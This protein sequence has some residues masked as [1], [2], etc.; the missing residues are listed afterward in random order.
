MNG[1]KRRSEVNFRNEGF[2]VEK[3]CRYMGIILNSTFY[4]SSE[5]TVCGYL[6]KI[7]ISKGLQTGVLV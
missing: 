3:L 5:N 2:T 1:P 7:N 6:A 4:I